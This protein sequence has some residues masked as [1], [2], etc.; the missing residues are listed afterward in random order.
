M[1]L[2]TYYFYFF[3]LFISNLFLFF[4]SVF[5]YLIIFFKSLQLFLSLLVWLFLYCTLPLRDMSVSSQGWSCLFN[6]LGSRHRPHCSLLRD[7][8][9]LID[10]QLFWKVE[11]DMSSLTQMSPASF[12]HTA[13]HF[14]CGHHKHAGV[15]H[16]QSRSSEDMSPVWWWCWSVK[17]TE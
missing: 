6:R 4:P 15:I 5:I 12:I 7:W 11:C 17:G 14:C 10:F 3:Y 16:C 8:M 13:W 2:L 1:L 9:G